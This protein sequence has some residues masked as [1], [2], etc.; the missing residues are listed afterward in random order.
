[1]TVNR[2]GNER[3]GFLPSE[4]WTI[5]RI[6]KSLRD[7]IWEFVKI[8]NLLLWD[9]KPGQHARVSYWL[10]VLLGR[11]LGRRGPSRHTR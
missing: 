1:M 6:S 5:L 7:Q 9:K 11:E 2:I 10:P 3:P 8:T 4:K